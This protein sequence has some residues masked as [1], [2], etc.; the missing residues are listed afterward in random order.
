MKNKFIQIIIFV[1][2][3]SLIFNSKLILNEVNSAV[4]TFIYV[5]FPS[6][7]PFFLISNIL[8]NY[9]F[10]ETLNKYFSKITNFL[11]H[12]SNSSNFVI[13]MSILSGFPSGSKYIT[14]LY[15][16]NILNLNQANYLITFTH[17]SNPLFV[18]AIS[19]KLFTNI[20]ITYMILIAHIVS[21]IIIGII[22]R[23]KEKEKTTSIELKITDSF[24]NILSNS[25]ISSLKLLSIILGN[26]CF[27]FIISGLIT[28]YIDLSPI[29]NIL[30]NGFFDIT[31][32]VNTL[33]LIDNELFKAI[34]ILTF[35]GF[36][37]INIHM[38]VL[39]IIEKTKIKYKN[40]LLGRISQV[41]LSVIIFYLI[42]LI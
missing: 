29:Q 40:F 23:P 28:T 37:G 26:T 25:I 24:S 3:L 10:C 21:N 32:G 42:Y 39:N 33:N 6:I 18:I 27:F 9:N 1:V 41:G 16:K 11:F 14:E 19:S 5:L 15:N 34:L 17:F 8:I 31:K 4:N 35:I 2:F 36:G 20:K 13:I 12:T 30:I 7:F 38:Q 22:I